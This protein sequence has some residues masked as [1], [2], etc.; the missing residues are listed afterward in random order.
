MDPAAWRA[1]RSRRSPSTPFEPGGT[2][3]R[4]LG[5][6][7]VHVH[8]PLGRPFDVVGA[9]RVAEPAHR[10]AASRSRCP[11]SSTCPGRRGRAS[12]GARRGSISGWSSTIVCCQNEP[13][14]TVVERSA[15][16]PMPSR[17]SCVSAPPATTGVPAGMPVSAA[18]AAVTSP[19]TVPDSST[20]G[21]CDRLEPDQLE[22][23]SPTTCGPARSNM[24]ELEPSDDVGRELAGQAGREPVAEH[25]DVADRGEHL[26]AVPGDPAQP[27]RGGDRDP[28][29]GARV[30]LLARRR[31]RTSSAA[32]APAR[33]STFGHAQI[34]R[35]PPS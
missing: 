8:R 31:T 15:R 24:P 34:S 12:A 23:R 2:A 19:I 13:P 18:A 5:Q 16:I 4:P 22:D 26:G 20:G 32:S 1:S 7:V 9:E 27:R 35:P 11:R 33:E 28:V 10:E 21:T 25:P 30:D 3:G 17:P 6:E 14:T 29:A